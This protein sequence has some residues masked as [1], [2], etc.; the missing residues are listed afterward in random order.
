MSYL[1]PDPRRTADW[2]RNQWTCELCHATLRKNHRS[3][4]LLSKGHIQRAGAITYVIMESDNNFS[5]F[6]QSITEDDL[7]NP[8]FYIYHRMKSKPLLYS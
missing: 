7:S 3:R 8:E 1:S 6:L 5:R 2:F 4:H